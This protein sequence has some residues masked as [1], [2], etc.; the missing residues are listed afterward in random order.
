M[1]KA[2][3]YF[4]GQNLPPKLR[5]YT[6]VVVSGWPE[7]HHSAGNP[8]EVLDF[9]KIKSKDNSEADPKPL[10]LPMARTMYDIIQE[11]FEGK[12]KPGSEVMNLLNKKRLKYVM[13]PEHST[14]K[15]VRQFYLDRENYVSERVRRVREWQ[16]FL[17]RMRFVTHLNTKRVSCVR[18]IGRDA[19]IITLFI[20]GDGEGF[21]SYGIGKGL[22]EDVAY[23]RAMYACRKNALYIPLYEKRTL[24]QDA[25]ESFGRSRVRLF[26][27]HRGAGFTCSQRYLAWFKSIGIKDGGMK[28]TGTRNMYSLVKAFMLC[29]EKQRSFREIAFGRGVDYRRLHNPFHKTPPAP[30]H[31]DI[32]DLEAEAAKNFSKAVTEVMNKRGMLETRTYTPMKPYFFN[33]DPAAYKNAWDAT[34]DAKNV[35]SGARIY[36]SFTDFIDA[37]AHIASLDKGIH[38]PAEFIDSV[39]VK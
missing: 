1:K 22:D 26:G 17:T 33:Y 18:S 31:E 6:P 23:R 3:H 36:P 5:V 34:F 24:F 28:L 16:K 10:E 27:L 35:P 13:R 9:Q 30:S 2:D 12:S 32:Q 14:S 11:G 37:S 4:F 20:M 15:K 39:L 21:F 8:A 38:E 19:H 25:H 7:D 29:L